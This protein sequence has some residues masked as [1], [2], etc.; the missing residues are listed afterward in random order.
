[1]GLQKKILIYA[2]AGLVVLMVLLTWLSSQTI[3][4][5]IDKVRQERVALVE[6]IAIDI[7]DVIEHLR[8]EIADAA[9]VLG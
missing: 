2:G 1:M 3:N 5:A 7:D 8:T 9:L 6:N 4:Q